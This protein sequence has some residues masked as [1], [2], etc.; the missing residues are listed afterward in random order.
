MRGDHSNTSQSRVL[1]NSCSPTRPL[2]NG[3][4]KQVNRVR[5]AKADR[6]LREEKSQK[7]ARGEEYDRLRLAKMKPPSFVETKKREL[8][9]YVD[10]N[11]T[12]T[13]TG[14]IGIHVGDDIREVAKN[15]C[16]AF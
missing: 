15:F 9:L 14:R 8:L 3:Y 16:K 2:P 13:K 12:P 10:V 6:D 5:Q 1:D 7:R 4:L 11:V